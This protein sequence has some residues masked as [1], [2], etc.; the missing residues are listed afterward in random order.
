MIEAKRTYSVTYAISEE[1]LPLL[2]FAPM[3]VLIFPYLLR[4]LAFFHISFVMPP[5][6]PLITKTLLTLVTMSFLLISSFMM[7]KNYG[8]RKLP[9][10]STVLG[11][12]VLVVLMV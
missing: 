8:S 11:F 12:L 10:P 6:R 3:T 7:R 4:L 9:L 5:V 1:N 2:L